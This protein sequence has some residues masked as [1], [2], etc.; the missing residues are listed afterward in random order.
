MSAP[1]KGQQPFWL[2][3][4]AASIAACFTHPLDQTKYRMQVQA[5]K[6]NM[7]RALVGYASR[8]GVFSLWSGL[9]ASLLRQSTYSTARF[10]VYN[11]FARQAMELSGKEKQSMGS[12]ITCAGLAGGMAGMIGNPT[13]V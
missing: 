6:Q 7:L 5:S 3:G 9:S 1:K 8:D 10:G 2:G 12:I 11:Y 4:V 13:E